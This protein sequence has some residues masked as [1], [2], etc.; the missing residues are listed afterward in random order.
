MGE[1]KKV[2]FTS[3]LRALSAEKFEDW[4]KRFPSR[5]IVMLTGD[6]L[7]DQR[8][9]AKQMAECLT[10]DIIICTSELLDSVTR[11]MK[12]D[13]N[14]WLMAV[15]LLVVDEV[16]VITMEGRGS[17]VESGIM[18]FTRINPKA[19]VL[20]LSATMS[21]VS[22]LGSWLTK[23]NGKPTE[24]LHSTY[25]PV[26]LNMNYVEYKPVYSEGYGGPR[27][28]YQATQRLKRRMA[29]DL[30]EGKPDEKFLVFVHDKNTGRTMIKELKERGIESVFHNADLESKDRKGIEDSFRQREGGLRVMVSTSTTAWGL[31][32]PARNVVVVGVHRGIQE[33]DEIDII[34]MC[35]RS[36]RT[37][38][39]PVGNAYLIIPEG[40]TGLWREKFLNPRP[41]RSVLK[42]HEVLAFHVLAEMEIR[43]VRN[44]RSMLEWYARSLAFSQ[45]MEFTEKDA[46]GLFDDLEKMEMVEYREDRQYCFITELGRV[47]AWLYY[48]PYTIYSWFRNFRRIFGVT[49]KL[50]ERK[51]A[52]YAV[53]EKRV[54]LDDLTL[55]WA[56]GD[57]PSADMGYVPKDVEGECDELSWKLRNRGV[58]VGTTIHHV[59]GCYKSLS[60]EGDE[61]ESLALRALKRTVRYDIRRV[62]QA[63]RL[64]DQRYAEWGKNDLW[65][66]L[67]D[68]VVYGIPQDMVELVKIPEVGAKRAAALYRVG[69][70]NAADVADPGKK[71]LV[72]RALESPAVI[73]KVIHNAK[74]MVK[75][76]AA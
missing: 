11:R 60:G 57:I 39:D 12:Q 1:L 58:H 24:I 37:G 5:K 21:N 6:T 15:G 48:D 28:N 40:S 38:I 14:Q 73:N 3:P 20:F 22:E 63:L 59:L 52:D 55:A 42:N 8:E 10:A 32:T 36:G 45:G 26:K 71:P 76:N 53:D 72:R 30:V 69:L 16:H 44:E 64:I 66:I 13:K 50:R 74:E 35:G 18:R 33:V 75:A 17:A 9:R 34:Q 70:R 49:D 19:K 23:L 47:S 65:E 43:D 68:R 2:I 25:R 29:L 56:L 61:E 67:P 4:K 7:F 31:N 46:R 27:L 54:E 41:I 62:V 51:G